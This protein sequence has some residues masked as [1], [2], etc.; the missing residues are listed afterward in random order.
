ML[1][2]TDNPIMLFNIDN[3][4]MSFSTDNPILLFSTQWVPDEI[5]H[6]III[7]TKIYKIYVI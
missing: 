7:V 5:A 6:I 3:P 4:I 1:F 2:G